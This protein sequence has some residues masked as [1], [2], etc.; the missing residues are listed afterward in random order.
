MVGNSAGV[1]HTPTKTVVVPFAWS[2]QEEMIVPVR[3][4]GKPYHMALDT[5]AAHTWVMLDAAK[6]LDLK[7][8]AP[9]TTAALGCTSTAWNTTATVEFAGVIKKNFDVRVSDDHLMDAQGLVG[10][11]LLREFS[12]VTID[13]RRLLLILKR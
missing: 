12:S 7:L 6:E 10:S 1:G 13:Y 11:N 3:V 2:L 5:G 9:D 4:N 8:S